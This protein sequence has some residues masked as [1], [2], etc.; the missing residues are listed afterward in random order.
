MT[1][2]NNTH[3]LTAAAA[4]GAAALFS[5]LSFGGSAE[6]SQGPLS[7][8]GSSAKKVLDCCAEAINSRPSWMIR[9]GRSCHTSYVVFC[10]RGTSA[11]LRCYIAPRPIAIEV[12]DEGGGGGGGPTVGQTTKSRTFN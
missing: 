12:L 3:K 6:A 7:C 11:A 8:Q 1:K 4:F 10:K 2:F 5:M 9:T